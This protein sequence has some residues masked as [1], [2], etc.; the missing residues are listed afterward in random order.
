MPISESGFNPEDLGSSGR[1]G[2]VKSVAGAVASTASTLVPY[3]RMLS[4][5][6]MVSK[7]L[8][9]K[10]RKKSI[11]RD[12]IV[13]DNTSTQSLPLPI[14]YGECMMAGNV[15]YSSP[16]IWAG[17]D[18][19]TNYYFIS[20][21]YGEVDSCRQVKYNDDVV[22]INLSNPN[23]FHGGDR[24]EIWWD[25]WFYNGTSTQKLPDQ[26]KTNQDKADELGIS[27]AK[28]KSG[29]A[30]VSAFDSGSGSIVL[31]TSADPSGIYTQQERAK[32]LGSMKGVAYAVVA[33]SRQE[34]ASY[35]T[36]SF[37]FK[38]RGLKVKAWDGSNWSYPSG[39]APAG[40]N[41]VACLRDF[42]TNTY[43][44]CGYDES[45][46][47]NTTW[48][49]A[50]DYCNE[51]YKTG[52]RR[53][54][55]NLVIDQRRPRIDIIGDMLNTFQ[56]YLV[57]TDGKLKLGINKNEDLSS[58]EKY[59]MDNIIKNSFSCEKID[60]DHTPNKIIIEYNDP[61][62][63]NNRGYAEAEDI[64]D[65]NERGKVVDEIV[66]IPG[67]NNHDQ[68][69]RIANSFLYSGVKCETVCRFETPI[70]FVQEVGDVIKVSHDLP[71]WTE[72][73]FRIIK[74]SE[75]GRETVQF[76]CVEYHGEVFDDLLGTLPPEPVY[77]TLPNP[78]R[79]VAD[80][81]DFTVI[82]DFSTLGNY[83]VTVRREIIRNIK[84]YVDTGGNDIVPVLLTDFELSNRNVARIKIHNILPVERDG[85]QFTGTFTN[86]GRT[87]L[88]H[89]LIDC[90]KWQS[91]D[92]LNVWNYATAVN[93]KF[94]LIFDDSSN[95][96]IDFGR[97]VQV[98][99]AL[100]ST[101]FVVDVNTVP[102]SGVFYVV[103]NYD[104]ED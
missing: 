6:F 50:Y 41:P 98:Q 37:E 102:D 49:S 64:D 53:Y 5:G 11:W 33:V 104:I 68:A 69:A 18:F 4:V 63:A 29:S 56:G 13:I 70:G 81:N 44:G 60:Y 35:S 100:T 90:N 12:A 54:T 61:D 28:Y 73:P 99:R 52:Q 84:N 1:W 96:C 24:N 47:D 82:S 8:L 66:R 36:P 78:L 2:T 9:G 71:S 39:W 85:W 57:Y 67:I 48:G 42:L 77:S 7:W 43:Y 101:R 86:G 26:V 80:I 74:M 30:F 83:P 10:D 51:Y 91:N 92:N 19:V 15:V 23:F 55:L 27:D 21:G 62:K 88:G 59:N 65:I 22:N 95:D 72:K 75:T 31:P 76:E 58:V 79:N 25:V 94:M 17:S 89:Y 20:F 40:Y 16:E 3:A 87:L 46:I 34:W 45:I 14:V 32:L 38:I 97:I 93:N 103:S